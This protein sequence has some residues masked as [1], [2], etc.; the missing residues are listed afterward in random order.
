MSAYEGGSYAS[1][2]NENRN[3]NKNKVT[4]IS[5]PGTETKTLEIDSLMHLTGNFLLHLSW[6]M[7]GNSTFLL[8]LECKL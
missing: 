2:E 7:K 5:S 1:Y 3:K 4:S 8:K 6:K